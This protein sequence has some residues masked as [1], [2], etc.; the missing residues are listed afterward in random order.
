MS[1]KQFDVVENKRK[2]DRIRQLRVEMGKKQYEV[3]DFLS[4]DQGNYSKMELGKMPVDDIVIKW[5]ETAFHVFVRKRCAE[6]DAEKD[7]LMNL[8][9]L[10]PD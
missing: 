9:I 5:I 7:R 2:A 10:N 4:I 6:L 1:K 8:L 3:A